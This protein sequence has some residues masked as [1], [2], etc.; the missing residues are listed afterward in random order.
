MSLLAHHSVFGSNTI[1]NSL[2]PPLAD[3]VCFSPLRIVVSLT[4]FKTRLLGRSF[5]TIIRNALFPS[6]IDVGSHNPPPFEGLASS[7]A[8]CPLFG[9][10]TIC[11]SSN[12]P[13]AD[14]VCFGPLRIVVSLSVFKTCLLGRGFHTI[15]RNVL[16]RPPTD[17]GSQNPPSLG[18]QRPR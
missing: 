6:L 13:L 12:P 14:I 3:I 10:D 8:H 11:N 15:I 17:V 7:L 16:F 2:N 4:V 5:H 18:A 9:S 1:C